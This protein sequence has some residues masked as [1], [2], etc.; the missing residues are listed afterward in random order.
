M[1]IFALLIFSATAA[2]L[3]SAQDAAPAK[4]TISGLVSDPAA[5]VGVLR[6]EKKSLRKQIMSIHRGQQNDTTAALIQIGDCQFRAWDEIYIIDFLQEQLD[7]LS[8]T[9]HCWIIKGVGGLKELLH[10]NI[11]ANP[12]NNVTI[13]T[14]VPLNITSGG[15]T[16]SINLSAHSYK[17]NGVHEDVF[18][19]LTYVHLVSMTAAF[20]LAYPVIL[21]LASTPSLCVM[22]D[23]PLDE[24]TKA[25][26][27]RWQMI[28]QSF[29]FAP[30]VIAGLVTGII[31]M[32]ESEHAR[33]QHGIIG[34]VTIAL[35]AISVP[36]YL[37]QRYLS[38]RPELSFNMFR[39]LK[40]INALDF[41]ICQ[42]I[43][44]ISG[45]ALPDGIDDFGIMTLCGTNTVSTSLIFSLGMIVSFVWNCAMA[46]MTVQW[47][48]EQR[49][50]GGSIRDRA[51]PWMLKVLRKRSN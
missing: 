42:A 9:D 41:T 23:R 12:L 49:V 8:T 51:P 24:L 16:F 48:L 4:G 38:F 7:A 1:L 43:L 15:N 39:R 34:F 17:V 50:R 40:F 30:L 14:C 36:L 28:F 5:Q 35:A 18:V 10:R 32:G 2:N 19:I 22:I 13:P 37:Y 26:V 47:L 31:A 29:V 27:E 21:V 46:T 6:T 20:F 33:T 45:F 3:G 11:T 25:K 44:I